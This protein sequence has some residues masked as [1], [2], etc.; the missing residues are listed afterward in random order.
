MKF[1]FESLSAEPLFYM[2]MHSG[3]FVSVLGFIF[4]IIGLLFG[5]ATWGRYKRLTRDL[6]VEAESMKAEIAD[7][8]RKVGDHS[9]KPGAAIEMATETI[10]LP[11]KEDTTSAESLP[12]SV[13]EMPPPVEVTLTD[14][15]MFPAEPPSP[16]PYSSPFDDI[17]AIPPLTDGFFAAEEPAPADRLPAL[18]DL[19]LTPLPA[20]E[21][22]PRKADDL[23]VEVV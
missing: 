19:A 20:V 12:A 7:L 10:D 16:P 1:D 6:R 9:V 13:S 4:F 17:N 8:K 14:T 2:L 3:V 5:Y 11:K 18:T 22:Q 21:I 15:A 23:T